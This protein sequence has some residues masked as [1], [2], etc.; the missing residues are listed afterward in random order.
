MVSNISDKT[1]TSREITCKHCKNKQYVSQA[2]AE[3]GRLYCYSCNNEIK[4]EEYK[5]D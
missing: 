5:D 1:L 4:L 3:L 2:L